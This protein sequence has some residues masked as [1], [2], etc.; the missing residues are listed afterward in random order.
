MQLHHTEVRCFGEGSAPLLSA[1]FILHRLEIDR[2]GAVRTLQRTAVGEFSDQCVGP[3]NCHLLYTS[4]RPRVRK[5]VSKSITSSAIIL[6]SVPTNCCARVST[7][8]SIVRSPSH[9]LRISAA[10]SF[11]NRA[12]SGKT[13]IYR[14]STLSQRSRALGE[15]RGFQV[16]ESSVIE[17][18]EM[19]YLPHKGGSQPGET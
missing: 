13:S 19:R 15:R 18:I 10:V 8:C 17:V 3:G 1:E 16:V 12:A 9:S 5:R 11:N 2:I 7:I 14:F 6:R 4:S